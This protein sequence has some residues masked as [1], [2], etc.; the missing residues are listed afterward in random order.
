M[1][2]LAIPVSAPRDE[3]VSSGSSFVTRAGNAYLLILSLILMGYAL[4]GRG[5]AYLGAPPIFVGEIALVL[6]L[7][8][9][10]VTPKWK[11]LF[12]LPQTWLL[13]ALCAWSLLRTLPF[14]GRFG[15]DALRDAAVWG[16][17]AFAIVLATLL[18]AE[19]TRLRTLERYYRR[20]SAIFMICIPIICILYRFY[21]PGLPRWPWADVPMVFVKEADA[22]VHLAGIIAFWTLF[23]R[24][25][26][27][28]RWIVLMVIDVGITAVI[29]RSGL[30]AFLTV[31]A[32]CVIARPRVPALWGLFGVILLGGVTLWATNFHYAIPGGKEREI[33]AEQFVT[34][35]TSVAGG[36]GHE[37]LDGTKE[38]RLQWWGD[39]VD[40]TIHGKYFWSGKGYGINLADDDGYQVGN[41]TLRSPHNVHMTFLARSGV[42]GLVLWFLL[43]MSFAVGLL[44]CFFVSRR[45][46]GS[47]WPGLFLFIFCFWLAFLINGSFDV[48]IEGPPGGIWFWC[49]FG[50]GLGAIWIYRNQ[51]EIL[52]P[53]SVACAS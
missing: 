25:A 50:F 12:A 41:K 11:R 45:I 35:L 13:A 5:F 21:W 1:T 28:F 44:R 9:F 51:P 16:Y 39:I 20:F 10:L 18:I 15:V 40:Y 31:A 38:W 47:R 36:T 17:S 30:I 3:L 23:S 52:D 6:G 46:A 8:A 37:G 29:D 32:I 42:P 26:I 34:N 4:D 33:S 43:Q 19:P 48:F 24:R 2:S 7:N 53:T 22:M 27:P 14:V 49:V